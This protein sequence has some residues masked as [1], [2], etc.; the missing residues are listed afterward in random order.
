[1]YRANGNKVFYHHAGGDVDLRAVCHDAAK[2]AEMLNKAG[3]LNN[4]QHKYTAA[5]RMIAKTE[6]LPGFVWLD[7]I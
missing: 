1:M 3:D 5:A 7:G 4:R 2:A 6:Y